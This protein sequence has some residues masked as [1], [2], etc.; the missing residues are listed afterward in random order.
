MK[1]T[2][3]YIDIIDVKI[4]QVERN[5]VEN[6]HEDYHYLQGRLAVLKELREI[7]LRDCEEHHADIADQLLKVRR[8]VNK[9]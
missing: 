4:K 7:A 2:I 6:N 5:L 8:V 9:M 3:D 1:N